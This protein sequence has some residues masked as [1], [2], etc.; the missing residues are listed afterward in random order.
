[1]SDRSLGKILNR[2]NLSLERDNL[3]KQTL[4]QLREKLLVDRIVLYYFYREW[5][6]QVTCESLVAPK[7]SILGSTGPDECF[8]GEYARMYE[9]GRVRA[10]ENIETE[11]IAPC[12]RDFLRDLQ[13]KGNLVVPVID[14]KRLWGLLIAHQC[15]NTRIWYPEDIQA[16]QEAATTLA[17]SDSIKNS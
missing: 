6:G 14:R 5:E 9:Q 4:E 1:M 12:H 3:V 7:F 15:R 11:A 13:V 2:I 10:I 8:N 17:C 16:I